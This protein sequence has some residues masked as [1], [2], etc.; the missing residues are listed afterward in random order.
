MRIALVTG[1]AGFIGRH[2]IRELLQRGV[3]VR[4]IDSG[5]TGRID[6]VD[7]TVNL[8]ERDIAD[9]S[10]KEWRDLLVDVDVVFHL[11]AQKYNTP[12]ITG[13]QILASNVHATWRLASASA[14]AGTSRF[15]FA[16]SLY[17]YGS[18]GPKI[19]SESDVPHPRTLYGAS[20]LM[21]EHILNVAGET[22]GLSWQVARLFFVYGPGQF[23]DGGYKS[24]IV[25]NFERIAGGKAPLIN[26]DGHQSLDYIF[27]EDAVS[28][29]IALAESNTDRLTVNLSSGVATPVQ[30]LTSLMI[31]ISGTDMLP[32]YA[33][34][35]WT[36][37]TIRFGD[38]RLSRERLQWTPSVTLQEGL[39]RTW[40]SLM[41]E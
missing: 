22:N 31:E 28:G 5:Q 24:V 21:G 10:A 25:S 20:K 3:H 4:T 12:G 32:E 13:D 9:V 17:A 16:S 29:L 19:M 18:L 14:E 36:A 35:D 34:S 26:G 8:V 38:T 30:E 23:A 11:A 33:P 40:T 15:V 6:L 41:S 39:S 1:G 37:S 2:L 7:S 27:V